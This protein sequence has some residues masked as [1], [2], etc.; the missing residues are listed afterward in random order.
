[1]CP[2]CM[3]F[4][5]NACRCIIYHMFTTSVCIQTP[6]FMCACVCQEPVQQVGKRK[7]IFNVHMSFLIGM[8]PWC[9]VHAMGMCLGMHAVHPLFACPVLS[10]GLHFRISCVYFCRKELLLILSRPRLVW[11][12][13]INSA[14]LTINYEY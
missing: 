2:L 5:F 8:H 6:P 4:L 7:I 3:N 9:M 14:I 1:M 13:L 11:F 10:L 12:V